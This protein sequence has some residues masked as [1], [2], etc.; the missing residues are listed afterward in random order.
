M[1]DQARSEP[2]DQ[3]PL[4]EAVQR[5]IGVQTLELHHTHGRPP[6]L[7]Y[8]ARTQTDR[9]FI[10]L[11]LPNPQRQYLLA[12]EAW[13]LQKA[14]SSG[15]PVPE[16]LY[17]DCS[18]RHYP[19]RYLVMSA[20]EGI[21]LNEAALP[22][23]RENEVLREVGRH[24]VRLHKTTIAG[25]GTLD[26]DLYLNTGEVRGS[27]NEW[28]EPL[29][30]EA[31]ASL[32]RLAQDGLIGR[33]E[34]ESV[35][36]RLSRLAGKPDG[37]GRLLH[38]DL[39]RGTILVEPTAGRLTGIIDFNARKSGPPEWEMATFLVWEDAPMLRPLVE[40]YRKA[41]GVLDDEGIRDCGLLR[42]LEI[43]AWYSEIG[44]PRRAAELAA[45]LAE[46]L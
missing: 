19:F 11:E 17:V 30:R 14:A 42:V 28:Y 40:G 8:E 29:R 5:A 1:R 46:F 10:K 4:T 25:S 18:E 44:R 6:R 27:R 15:V 41:G 39:R 16:V 21:W 23:E 13:A 26:D 32:T 38:S 24:L 45:R 3:R 12:L 33:H 37:V 36:E 22:R 20:I 2:I 7:V 9:Y 43:A 35:L 31:L 34:A